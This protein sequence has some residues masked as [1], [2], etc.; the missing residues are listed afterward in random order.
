MSIFDDTSVIVGI[1]VL[2]MLNTQQSIR[3]NQASVTM[4]LGT[5]LSRAEFALLA[6]SRATSGATDSLNL[7]ESRLLALH[8]RDDAANRRRRMVNFARKLGIVVA[9]LRMVLID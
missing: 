4:R 3:C 9:K 5:G 6:R 7:F 1:V 8:G 2:L